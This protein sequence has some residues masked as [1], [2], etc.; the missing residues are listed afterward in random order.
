MDGV[1][2]L[3]ITCSQDIL[4]IFEPMKQTNTIE[5]GSLLYKIFPGTIKILGHRLFG[6]RGGWGKDDKE[7]KE[8]TKKKEGEDR[9][10]GRFPS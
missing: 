1:C 8:L 3:E 2:P 4:C 9:K 6:A 10:D 7:G 5:I